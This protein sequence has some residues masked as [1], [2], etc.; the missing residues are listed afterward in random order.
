ARAPRSTWN[1]PS[2]QRT[3]DAMFPT[4]M[5]TR[6]WRWL[7]R[8]NPFELPGYA[9]LDGGARVFPKENAG[10]VS[11]P[12][13][14]VFNGALFNAWEPIVIEDG[15][16]GGHEVMFLTGRHEMTAAGASSRPSSRGPIH[17]GRGALIGSRALILG[18]VT[19]GEASVVG[20]GAVV[21]RSIPAN[22]FW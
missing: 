5:R 13:G 12:A 21:T 11:A 20:A 7:M 2:R 8:W 19:I 6:L 10:L 14:M 16:L 18:G 22:E 15:V 3:E 17:V 1:V 9:Y 4:P